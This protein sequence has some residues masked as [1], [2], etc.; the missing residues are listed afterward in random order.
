MKVQK[1]LKREMIAHTHPDHQVKAVLVT[2][3]EENPM[4]R[5]PARIN[6][7]SSIC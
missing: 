1:T 4:E 5:E 2:I 6:D 3:G 7:R